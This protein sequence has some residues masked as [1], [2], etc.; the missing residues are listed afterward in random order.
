M[1]FVS[2][3]NMLQLL[4]LASASVGVSSL[5]RPSSA[6]A[7]ATAIPKRIVFFYTEQGTRR[8]R[9]NDGSL[10]TDWTPTVVNAPAA[11]SLTKPWSTGDFTLGPTHQAL[12]PYQKK[13]TFL[14]G[15][16]MI[17][18]NL[19]PTS[20]SN[21]HINGETHALIGANRQT[22]TVAGGQS[23]DQFIAQGLTGTLLPSLELSVTSDSWPYES[24][25]G[26]ENQPTYSGPGMP[27]PTEGNPVTVFNR[28]YPNGVDASAAAQA[29]AQLQN[30]QQRS[31]LEFA[32]GN[33][34]SLASSSGKLD[35]DR[36]SAHAAAIRDLESRLGLGGAMSSTC[37]PPASDLLDAVKVAKNGT[38]SYTAHTDVFLQLTQVALA[39]NLAPVVTLCL[40]QAP[41]DL[42]GYQAGML[43]TTDFHDMV[44]QTSG[45][46]SAPLGADPQATKVVQAYHSY[47][48]SIFARLLA[49]L[50][51]T[52]DQG[53][54]TLLDNTVVVWCGQIAGGDHSLDNLPYILAG[55]LGGSINP[56]R[57]V[58]FPR[59]PNKTLWPQYSTGPA[60]NDLFVALANM[61][62]V[63]ATTFGNPDACKGALSGWT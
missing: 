12:I 6:R 2:R 17:S 46:M 24:T 62:G 43:G 47:N 19:D 39:C 15:L 22:D 13:L 32:A 35:A 20:A 58:R 5:W 42:F 21:A 63:A 14:D 3:R 38:A 48:A 52:P 51:S 4:G 41:D 1:T 49:L 61:M 59:A 8:L 25:G 10:V 29:Q 26:A 55:G 27:I 36:L 45:D 60:H 40:P 34:T 23:I 28:M 50:D 30:T 33:F 11:Q 18:A 44:H 7:D 31:V 56:G 9:N 54:T 53:G 37:T 57:Y 16:D